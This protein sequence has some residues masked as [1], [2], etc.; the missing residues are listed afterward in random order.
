QMFSFND[1]MVIASKCEILHLSSVVVTNNDE[2]IPKTEDDYFKT[3]VSLEAL[4]KA[5]PNVKTFIYILPENSSNIFTTKTAEELLKIPQFLSLDEF[6]TS[7]I[8]EIFDIKSFYGHITENKKTKYNLHFSDQISDA[9]K[10]RLQ[11]IV[12]EIIE[13]ENR[14]YKVPNIVFSGMT[15]DFRDKIFNLYNFH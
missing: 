8:P 11:T 5:L 2:V 15:V 9:Y 7:E 13:T 14:N 6:Q 3:P 4:V 1:L 10:T 12:Y